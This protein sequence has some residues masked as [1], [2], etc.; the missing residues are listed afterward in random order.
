MFILEHADSEDFDVSKLTGINV[1]GRR[2]ICRVHT[3]KRQGY[4]FIKNNFKT[5]S[6][7]HACNSSWSYNIPEDYN[8][9]CFKCK[10]KPP[11]ILFYNRRY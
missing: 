1:E 9:Y 2:S 7:Y 4:F 5:F 10:I 8:E 11:N 6:I 3:N